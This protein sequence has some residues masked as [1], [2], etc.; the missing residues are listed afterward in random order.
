M[1]GIVGSLNSYPLVYRV[2]T[3]PQSLSLIHLAVHLFIHSTNVFIAQPQ[4][5][6][7]GVQGEASVNSSTR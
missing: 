2:Q 1:K 6:R 7:Q 3:E 4:G 5:A